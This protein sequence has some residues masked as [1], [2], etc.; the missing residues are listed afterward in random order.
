[1]NIQ[2][3]P[4]TITLTIENDINSGEYNITPC[5]FEF[6]EEY[7]GL[8]KEAIFSTCENTVKTAI[9]NNTCTIPS[10]VLQTSGNVL[11]GVFA[12]EIED[13][14]VS[15]RYSPTP[16]YFNVKEGSYQTGNDPDLP[17]PSEWE[18]VLEQ[19]NQ[20]ITET[21]N[22]NI[23]A[24]KVDHTTTITITRKDGTSYDV[25]VLDGNDGQQGPPGPP[26]AVK[27]LIVN[28]L[29]TEDIQT[30]AIYL[31]PRQ[32][33]TQTDMYD[34]Y[35][36][37]NNKWELLGEKQITVDLTDYVKN[38]DYATASKGGVIKSGYYGLQVDSSNGKAYCD[39]Y[40]YANYGNV[41]NQRFISKGTLENVITGK[42]LET[43]TN[44]VTTL[45]SSSTD[46]QYPSAKCVYD[47]VG[48]IETILTTI[49]IGNGVS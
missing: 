20:A 1:M 21:N 49:D 38:T 45:S 14:E 39:T 35:M 36:Y 16:V 9:L 32:D 15:L 47:L 10:E 48:N 7:E 18:Q 31:V 27:F 3:N 40:T 24:E 29:P 11:V 23:E 12:Y 43:S 6:S 42:S 4:H 22:L 19:I 46:T 26:G 28:E 34:E 25:Q 8:T 37:V 2:V 41:E 13:E 30:D 17:E 5:T 33:P 44:K